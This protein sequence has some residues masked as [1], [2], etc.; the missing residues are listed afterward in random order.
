VL[1]LATTVGIVF[2]WWAA[3]ALVLAVL[4][5]RF[6]WRAGQSDLERAFDAVRPLER[7]ELYFRDLAVG[8]GAAKEIRVFGLGPWLRGRYRDAA[9]DASRELW[10]WRFKIFFKPFLPATAISLALASTVFA[11]I[12]HAGA[13]HALSLHD[14]ALALQASLVALSVAGYWDF[15]DGATSEGIRA[16]HAI[17]RFEEDVAAQT[18]PRPATTRDPAG[19]PLREIRFEHVAFT[20]PGAEQPV[21]VDLDLTIPAGRSL[22]IVGLNG[23]GKTT[24]VKLLARLYE[25]S[26]GRITADGIDIREFPARA[27]QRRIGAIFQ[28]FV[29]YGLSV[30]DNV[31]F[32]A[33]DRTDDLFAI[34]RALGRV[35]ALEHAE[36]LAAG[37]DTI[38]SRQYAGGTDLSGGQW[39]R[40]A[41]A[42][43]LFA[44]EGG[45]SVLVLDEPTANLDV[46]AEAAFFERFI[47]LT[48][49]LTTIVISHRF[50]TVRRADRIVVLE[51]GAPIEDGTH[52]DLLARGGRYAELFHLQAKRFAEQAAP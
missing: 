36:R 50:S 45:A 20:Y 16:I 39:Q 18:P 29:H 32:G 28:D 30:H 23:A 35:G 37:L 48:E 34:R 44:V 46:R 51:D 8:A 19:L 7:R 10:R 4:S 47:E 2:A 3:L 13:Q 27:W 11:G 25:P 21:F 26:S 38:L 33:I 52:A 1:V 43:A 41:I 42:R 31:A 14:L 15:A 17:S 24:L 6:V 22:A 5:L 49:G 9:L 12:G 40:I